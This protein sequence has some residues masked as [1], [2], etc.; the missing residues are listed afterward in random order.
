MTTEE[1]SFEPQAFGRFYLVDR[2]ATGGMAEIFKA[3]TFSEGG[4][5]NLLVIKRILPHIGTNED[6]VE[7]FIDEAK[8]SAALQHANIVRIYDFGKIHD[9]YF[10][11]ME[12]VDGK[13][14][15]N[16]LRKLGRER[17]YMPVEVAAFIT[18]EIAKGLD[19]AHGKRD[20]ANN[21]YGIIHR[22]IS[23]SNLL[24]SYEGEVKIADFGIAK[25][26]SNAYQT[27]DGVLKGKFEY[28]SPEQASGR[29]IDHRSDLFS[30]GIILWEMLT[31]RRLFKTDSEVAT[32][33]K[34]RECDF[35]PP[36][37][38]NA[39]IPEALE[40]IVMKAL[41]L[42]PEDRYQSG[43]QMADD[44]RAFLM[45]KTPDSVRQEF[46]TLL[47]E[48]FAEEIESERLRLQRGSVVALDLHKAAPVDGW[49][50]S[51]GTMTQTAAPTDTRA[52]LPW[53]GGLVALMLVFGALILG[54]V[55]WLLQNAQ[56]QPQPVPQPAVV[57]TTGALDVIVLP[58][59]RILVNGK[60]EKEGTELALADLPP[61]SY[62]IRLE[63]EGH[64]PLEEAVQVAAGA[65]T[66]FARTLK[67]LPAA[68]PA[69]APV[70]APE[71]APVADGPPKV[72]FTSSPDGA[73]VTIDGKAVGRTPLTWDKGSPGSTY[74][75]RL[76]KEGYQTVSLSV[77]DLRKGESRTVNKSLPELAR[78]G[79]LTVTLVG[80]GWANVYVDGK[81]LPKTAPLKDFTLPAGPHTIKVENEALGVLHEER[82][83][84]RSGENAKVTASP[85]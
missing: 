32:L 14:V 64:E 7:M 83:T 51:P 4:F 73:N 63:A 61:G 9:N 45:P 35:K 34:I 71:P 33:K 52:M 20:I 46:R 69:P 44:L 84:V 54:G 36:T 43:M 3:K 66:R 65:P 72:R 48:L 2:I 38:L 78:D 56:V 75:V 28:M 62:Q 16:L 77:E 82:I 30:L 21:P 50:R 41:S 1:Q 85:R 74:Q 55:A 57:V 47:H 17:R 39:R 24:L 68:A 70:A 37:K 76:S 40:A 58:A 10:I 27:R 8:V 12:C 13:D 80:A 26:E 22:D 31:G 11:A 60:L 79:T 18:H 19:Y 81:K 5:E 25:A 15:R 53:L 6:F 49:E 59:A 67:R 23:P 29:E 42:H